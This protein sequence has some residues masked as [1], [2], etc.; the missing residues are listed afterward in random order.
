[1][2]AGLPASKL[3][4]AACLCCRCRSCTLASERKH[5][6]SLV[7]SLLTLHLLHHWTS[8][9]MLTWLSKPKEGAM[10]REASLCPALSQSL[11]AC[12]LW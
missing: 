5:L 4:V 7:S 12:A 9:Q 10:G 1:M 11:A 3:E 8:K 6:I 2:A